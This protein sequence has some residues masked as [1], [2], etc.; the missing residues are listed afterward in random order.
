MTAAPRNHIPQD[1][2]KVGARRET[3]QHF[4]SLQWEQFINGIVGGDETALASLYD[5]TNR[6]LFGL[7]L[8]I[9]HDRQLA[10]EVLLDVYM[11]VWRQASVYESKRGTVFHWLVTITRSRAIDRLRSERSRH[12]HQELKRAADVHA[13]THLPTP[14]E[15]SSLSELR[16]HVRGALNM[17]PP[18]QRD[19][20][21]LA[22]F[23]GLSQTDLATKMNLPLGTVKTRVRSGM[24]KLEKELH[25][26]RGQL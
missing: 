22:Y 23:S 13:P 4:H 19:L 5:A 21:V 16:T 12:H 18:E 24:S 1:G 14:E 3:P 9:L 6:L 2:L 10:E 20:I 26:M 17:L 7:I 8:A 11:Q 25:P 15:E